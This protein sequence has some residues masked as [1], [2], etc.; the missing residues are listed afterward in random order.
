[1]PPVEISLFVIHLSHI[2]PLSFRFLTDEQLLA[3]CRVDHYRG[4]GP[5]G[6]HRNKTSNAVRLAHL[7]TGVTAV[8]TES[9]SLAENHRN[10]LRRLRIKIAA[11]IREPIEPAR[12]GP[13]GFDPPDWFLSIRQNRKI[14]VSSRREYYA[15]A[16]GL[17]LDV[18][19]IHANPAAA[20]AALGVTTNSIV[21]LLGQESEWWEA[22]NKM[23]REFGLAPLQS[24]P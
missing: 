5:G 9:R 7:A 11:E 20:A 21:Q 14:V 8:A 24:R 10:C 22:A 17:I 4:S 18:L 12:F 15:P 19:A 23:R 2:A 6:Q 1:M 3:G 16:A 13:A